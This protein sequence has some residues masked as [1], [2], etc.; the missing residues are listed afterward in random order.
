MPQLADQLKVAVLSPAQDIGTDPRAR[1]LQ[2]SSAL[3]TLSS[4]MTCVVSDKDQQHFGS[5]FRKIAMP[6]GLVASRSRANIL[7]RDLQDT[8]SVLAFVQRKNIAL[9][10]SGKLISENEL[11]TIID[12]LVIRYVTK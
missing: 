12:T 10:D 3:K 5:N 7:Y 2:A 6:L 1:L 9:N 4:V 11:V 8:E